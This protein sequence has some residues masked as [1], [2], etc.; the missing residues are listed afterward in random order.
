VAGAVFSDNYFNLIPG[1]EKRVKIIADMGG[2]SLQ[3]QGVNSSRVT[4]DL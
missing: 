2:K 3:I 1:E 4:L